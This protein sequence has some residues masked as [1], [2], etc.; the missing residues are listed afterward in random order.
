MGWFLCQKLWKI[1]YVLEIKKAVARPKRR[2]PP[3]WEDIQ[4]VYILLF[5][6]DVDRNE[7]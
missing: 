6:K 2:V 7:P 5:G 1:A 3:R 4:D